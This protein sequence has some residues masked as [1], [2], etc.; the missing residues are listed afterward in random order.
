MKRI[1]ARLYVK[2]ESVAAFKGLF[3]DLAEKTRQEDGCLFY[4]LYEDVRRPGEFL[5]YEEYC[6][7]AAVDRHMG[8]EY[9]RAFLT[10][11]ASMQARQ[12]NIEIL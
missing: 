8:S 6:D 11:T 4:C 12:P 1:I 2:E 3:A 10:G 9:L 7:Q 5:C